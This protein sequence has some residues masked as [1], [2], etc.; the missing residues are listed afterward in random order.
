MKNIGFI[1]LGIMGRPMAANLIKAGHT[2]YLFNRS[3]QNMIELSQIGGIPCQSPQEVA[4]HANIVFVMVSD[5]PDVE[6]VLFGPTGVIHGINPGSIVVDMSTISPLATR[7]F[8]EKLSN[9]GVEMLDA[10]VS[11]GQ[12]GAEQATLAIMVGGKKEIFETV[13]P[14][15]EIMGKKITLIGGNGDGQVC[16]MANQVVVALTIEAVGEALLLAGKAGVDVAKVREALLGGFAQSRI[17][18]VHGERMLRRTFQPGFKIRL[19]QKDLKIA[20][21]TGKEL[22]VPLPNCATAQELLTA[23]AA[24]GGADLDHSAMIRALEILAAW[25][26]GG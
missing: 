26:L 7:R 5:T 23:V 3:P 22:A 6:A 2:L 17:L 12:I 14:F 15:F 1:G 20:L 10:P 9:L 24:Q 4:A 21:Q 18:E 19:H 8:A 13:K 11:G 25:E 16:K